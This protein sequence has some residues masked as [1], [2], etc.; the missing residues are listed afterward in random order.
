MEECRHSRG[1]HNGWEAGNSTPEV[2]AINHNLLA[3]CSKA[4]RLG[5]QD[6]IHNKVYCNPWG[7]KESV[8]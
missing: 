8:Q 1:Y 3:Y 7:S 5:F 6:A 4:F 2:K